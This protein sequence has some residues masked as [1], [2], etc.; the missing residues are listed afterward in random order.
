VERSGRMRMIAIAV[1][2]L[3]LVVGV[4]IAVPWWMSY[5]AKRAQ[6]AVLGAVATSH[7]AEAALLPV[8][9]FVKAGFAKLESLG[10]DSAS[11]GV[12]VAQAK[13]KDARSA[14]KGA[15]GGLSGKEKALG[16]KANT[17][18]DTEAAGLTAAG[19][20]LEAARKGQSAVGPASTGWTA[21]TDERALVA[22]AD[23]AR[24][25]NTPASIRKSTAL[26]NQALA[27][28]NDA[29]Q[30]YADA[31]AA[32]PQG[33]FKPYQTYARFTI[34]GL[35]LALLANDA[36]LAGG[37]SAPILAKY[38]SQAGA[39]EKAYK[40]TR[41]PQATTPVTDGIR[42]NAFKYVADYL[43]ARS[44]ASVLVREIDSMMPK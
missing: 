3:V 19:H 4:A 43:Y 1:V 16:E 31:A 2:V 30:A 25:Q 37:Q 41:A 12:D 7:E 34:A 10:V 22:A 20:V 15:L 17:L 36:M 8:D 42:L 6:D 35:K 32:F 11:R 13:V 23:A 39:A 14:L 21:I 9:A 24:A 29:Q 18:L 27:K 40:T 28:A 5:R 26:L 38:R 33:T 44:R